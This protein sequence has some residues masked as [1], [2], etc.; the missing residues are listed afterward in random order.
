M[1]K[2]VE[3]YAQVLSY[4][5]FIYSCFGEELLST[6]KPSHREN[7]FRFLSWW[8]GRDGGDTKC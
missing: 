7:R 8:T 6:E 1:C 3:G 4:I 5:E 2:V